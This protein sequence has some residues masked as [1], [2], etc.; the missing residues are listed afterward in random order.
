MSIRLVALVLSFALPCAAQAEQL[1]NRYECKPRWVE[2]AVSRSGERTTVI[3]HAP[4]SQTAS[5]RESLL[6]GDGF[7]AP[8]QATVTSKGKQLIV[9]YPPRGIAVQGK[10]ATA[11]PFDNGVPHSAHSSTTVNAL[12]DPGS[13]AVQLYYRTPQRR[14][15]KPHAEGEC[16]IEKVSVTNSD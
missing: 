2:G 5:V 12:V 16:V 11:F 3:L 13:G 4:G 14:P 1:L 6:A 15:L 9:N 7:Y 10:T 8:V